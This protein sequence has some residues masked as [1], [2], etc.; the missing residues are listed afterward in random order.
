MFYSTEK[1]LYR[2]GELNSH[3]DWYFLNHYSKYGE[4]NKK[5]CF[6]YQSSN[7]NNLM[8]LRKK[9]NLNTIAGEGNEFQKQ[10]C[11]MKWI[12]EKL[13][14]KIKSINS[15][16]LT[17]CID[18]IEAVSKNKTQV[19]CFMYSIALNEVYLSMGYQSRVIRCLPMDLRYDDNHCVTLVYSNYFNKWIVMDPA[20][21]LYYL[22]SSGIPMSMLE[23]RLR[24]IQQKKIWMPKM[25]K[26]EIEIVTHYWLKNAFR[27]ECNLV[28]EYD[29][30]GDKKDR[31]IIALNPQNYNISD[32]LILTNKNSTIKYLSVNNEKIFWE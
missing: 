31:T 11:L 7:D 15:T 28:S 13:E 8:M 12:G 21:Q 1:Y 29:M 19:N 22:D 25:K 2:K 6:K 5:Y 16:N 20:M 9:Y 24:L 18:I 4:D 32:K 10:C 3:D 27:F 23:M 14:S 26:S 30:Y 17:N